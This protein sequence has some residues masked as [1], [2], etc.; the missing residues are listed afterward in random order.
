MVMFVQWIAKENTQLA[1]LDAVR[2]L[3]VSNHFVQ[4]FQIPTGISHG[5]PP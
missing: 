5:T 1:A 2:L 4:C 3:L